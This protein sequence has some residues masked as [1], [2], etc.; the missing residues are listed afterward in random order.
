MMHWHAPVLGGLWT[1]CCCTRNTRDPRYY[2]RN[3]LTNVAH[4]VRCHGWRTAAYNAGVRLRAPC[5]F[6]DC[7]RGG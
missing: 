1:E 4:D 6:V 3:L 7:E 5:W 2:E